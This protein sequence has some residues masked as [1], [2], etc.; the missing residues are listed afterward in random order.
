MGKTKKTKKKKPTPSETAQ[1]RAAQNFQILEATTSMLQVRYPTKTVYHTKS[2]ELWCYIQEKG[3]WVKGREILTKE[4]ERELGHLAKNYY[5]RELIDKIKRQTATSKEEFEK[6]PFNMIPLKNGVYNTVSR[7]LQKYKPEYNF[8]SQHPITYNKDADCPRIKKFLEETFYPEDL[9]ALQEWCGYCFY[10][11]YPIKKA[12]IV[13]GGRDTGKTTFIKLLT[14]AIGEELTSGIPLHRIGSKDKFATRSLYKKNMNIYDDLSGS[15][16]SDTGGLKI[17]TGGGYI[18]AEQKFGDTF[19]FKNFAK[20]IFA[21][22]K[23]PQPRDTYD[24]AYYSR[25]MVFPADSEPEKQDPELIYRLTSPQEISGFFLWAMD[26]LKSLLENGRFSYNKETKA[27]M[28][29]SSEPL[30]KFEA[31]VLR[32]SEGSTI[33]KDCMYAIYTAWAKENNEPRLSKEQLGRKLPRFVEYLSDG[34]GSG[35][36]AV[37]FWKNVKIVWSSPFY[38]ENDTNDTIFQLKGVENNI[39][40]NDSEIND[41]DIDMISKKVSQVS[42]TFKRSEGKVS[43]PTWK[44]E[45]VVSNAKN[46]TKP[47]YP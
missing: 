13:F 46:D 34:R 10:R 22:N 47:S 15:D 7:R 27:I 41:S 4:A 32:E 18:T 12:V 2:E 37:R 23:I 6:T 19:Q 26:G 3:I 44:E 42:Q 16:I 35:K 8:K 28:E 20:L 1:E 36:G 9:K 38:K 11:E 24:E 31:Q 21:C 40:N 33:T 39:E 45:V 14:F 30:K 17:A 43:K 5:V 25:W 29:R